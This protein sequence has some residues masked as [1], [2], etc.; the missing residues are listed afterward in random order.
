MTAGEVLTWINGGSTIVVAAATGVLAW[1]E[2]ARKGEQRDAADSQIGGLAFAVL[3]QIGSW[4]HHG[5]LDAVEEY[6]TAARRALESARELDGD[7]QE[8]L[9]LAPSAS[10]DV[11]RA[12]Q[13]GAVRF[14]QARGYLR[15]SL[16]PVPGAIL[17]QKRLGA[18]DPEAAAVKMVFN[19]G[20]EYADEAQTLLLEA[21]GEEYQPKDWD[22]EVPEPRY[23]RT[24]ET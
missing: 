5:E 7:V 24:E 17:S 22:D 12:V 6:H 2:I 4:R 15:I 21:V 11:A 10:A 16:D 19:R 13:R 8:L 20:F 3:R 1:R 9:R 23:K 14:Y 18:S